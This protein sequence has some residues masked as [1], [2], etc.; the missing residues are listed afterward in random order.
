MICCA[1]SPVSP[2]RLGRTIKK[3]IMTAPN[4]AEI[5]VE[6]QLAA[7]EWVETTPVADLDLTELRAY[8]KKLKAIQQQ[9]TWDDVMKLK[10][11]KVRFGVSG[12]GFP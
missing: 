9:R 12:S 3:T 10:S 2:A 8:R 6:R 4:F 1:G 7:T 5:L 11:P